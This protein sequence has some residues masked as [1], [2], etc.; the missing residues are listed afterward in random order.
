MTDASS[1]PAVRSHRGLRWWSLVVLGAGL[2]LLIVAWNASVTARCNLIEIRQSVMSILPGD[3]ENIVGLDDLLD[4][5]GAVALIDSSGSEWL[6]AG[7]GWDSCLRPMEYE[8]KEV[9]WT[10]QELPTGPTATEVPALPAHGIVVLPGDTRTE[11]GEFYVFFSHW[12][13]VEAGV[14]TDWWANLVLDAQQRPVAGFD[15]TSLV[16][17]EAILEYGAIPKADNVE[18]LLQLRE[19]LLGVSRARS[20]GD[21]VW[22]VGGRLEALLAQRG[23]SVRDFLGSPD[24]VSWLEW[25]PVDRRLGWTR[26]HLPEG[27][28][29]A[30]DIEWG[31]GEVVVIHHS[32]TSDSVTQVGLLSSIGLTGPEALVPGGGEASIRGQYARSVPLSL[33]LFDEDG[34]IAQIYPVP[35]TIL[36]ALDERIAVAVDLDL[37]GA[38]NWRQLDRPP[39]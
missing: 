4:G 13:G 24:L 32:L 1:G 18:A 38:E 15:E 22:T 25:D 3:S 14:S 20:M 2:V 34:D 30:L 39:S 26:N 31:N 29:D 11:A 27:A 7:S 12:D 23:E 33:V 8:V 21:P 28:A 35:E 19:D 10:A 17:L 9:L 36:R 16:E 37:R 6:D 5:V